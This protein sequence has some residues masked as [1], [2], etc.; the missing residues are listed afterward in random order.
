MSFL[1]NSYISSAVWATAGAVLGYWLV[2]W[3]ERALR[4][5]QALKEQ[6]ILEGARRQA[7]NITREARLQANEEGLKLREETEQ[8]FS[9]RRLAVTEAEK[10]LIERESLINHQLESMVQEEKSLREQQHDCKTK[11]QEL[12]LQRTELAGL[13]HQRREALQTVCHL[14]EAEARQLLLKEV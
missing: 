6:A 5:A 13:I 2:R 9:A 11:E 14:T 10:R 3:K 4:A 1:D 12:A 7:E 8:S